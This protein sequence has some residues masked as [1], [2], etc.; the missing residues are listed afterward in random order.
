M[1]EHAALA[2][3]RAPRHLWLVGIVGLL[4]NSVGAFDYVMM[5]TRN[6]SYVDPLTP[7]QLAAVSGFPGPAPAVSSLSA[8]GSTPGPCANAERWVA[9]GRRHPRGATRRRAAPRRSGTRVP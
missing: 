9:P 7:E 8:S 3:S 6:A 4:W 5:Q 1:K 2:P